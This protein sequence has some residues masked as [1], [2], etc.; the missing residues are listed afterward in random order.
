MLLLRSRDRNFREIKKISS[1]GEHPAFKGPSVLLAGSVGLNPDMLVQTVV[2][3]ALVRSGAKV[4]QV[5]CDAD[6]KVC[7]NAKSFHHQSDREMQRLLTAGQGMICDFCQ[8]NSQRYAESASIQKFWLAEQLTTEDLQSYQEQKCLVTSLHDVSTLR[9]FIFDGYSLGEHAY[10]A[11]VRFFASP[12]LTSE[13]N[14]LQIL[15]EYLLSSIKIAMSMTRF[16]AQQST[17]VVIVD[18]GIYVPQGVITEVAKAK[19]VRVITFNTGYRNKTF[20]FAE[21]DS[22]HF[23]LPRS[24]EFEG[25]RYSG[26][27]RATA[28][29]YVESRWSGRSDWVYFQPTHSVNSIT[30]ASS[31]THVALFPN[32]LWDA[33]IH[34]A[35]G[36]FPSSIDWLV[37]TLRYLSTQEN[38]VAH[39]RIHPGEKKGAIAARYG[40][41]DALKQ[42]GISASNVI[43]IYGPDDPVN[44]YQLAT[45]CD[46]SVVFGSKI[47]IDLAAM[48]CRVLTAGDC[49]TRGKKITTDPKN[50]EEYFRFLDNPSQIT[51][52]K[53]RG[54]DFAY[55]LYFE[56]MYYFDFIEK[57]VGDPPFLIDK[58][59]FN[60]SLADG[61]SDLNRLIDTIINS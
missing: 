29:E 39:V 52:S 6:L 23:V 43:K 38:T 8:R 7:F 18:H 46:Y 14:G 55:Y 21:G 32:V 48:G 37:E 13:P 34:F 10:S 35:E 26:A 47:G 1:A 19:G 28:Q 9:G 45:E 59:K 11:A 4:M 50:L 42:F 12:D 33:D 5:A 57:R 17:D 61:E 31:S 44:S 25:R 40:V 30:T 51:T 54:I 16:L 49:W 27:Q 22:Y 60:N 2:G 41:D 24:V 53:A 20:L 36:L 56:K 15:Q 3:L 58:N